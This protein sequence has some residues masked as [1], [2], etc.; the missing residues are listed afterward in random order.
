[1]FL[2]CSRQI[3]QIVAGGTVC[4]LPGKTLHPSSL[5]RRPLLIL[6]LTVAI[7]LKQAFT[8]NEPIVIDESRLFSL[9]VFTFTLAQGSRFFESYVCIIKTD[10]YFRD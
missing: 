8:N 7:L 6:R 5:L 2:A 10:Y 4:L 3:L 1:M 9:S